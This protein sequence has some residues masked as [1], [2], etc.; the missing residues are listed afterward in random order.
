MLDV[1]QSLHTDGLTLDHVDELWMSCSISSTEMTCRLLWC[2]E[3]K[4]WLNEKNQLNDGHE[5]GMI[6]AAMYEMVLY[7]IH[8]A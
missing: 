6:N 8:N 1:T 7:Q 3:L 4:H 2:N 5:N